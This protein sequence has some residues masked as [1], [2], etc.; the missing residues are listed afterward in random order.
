MA[1]EGPGK[2]KEKKNRAAKPYDRP[3]G[4]IRRVTDSVTGLFS[5]SWLSGWMASE[6]EEEAGEHPQADTSQIAS[7]SR[8][9]PQVNTLAPPGESFIFAQ[10]GASRRSFRP[11]YPEEGEI[12][13]N[14]HLPHGIN[15]GASTSAG[16]RMNLPAAASVAIPTVTSVHLSSDTPSPMLT[17]RRLPIVSSAP[18][19]MYSA[20]SKSHLEPR[21][22]PLLTS[23]TPTGDDASEFS[24]SSADTG[25]DASV[26]PRPDE[27]DYQREI[28]Q[29]DDESL[30][31]LR[32]SLAK[33]APVP[34]SQPTSA[35]PSLEETR[36]RPRDAETDQTSIR[37]EGSVSSRSLFSETGEISINQPQPSALA[38]KRPRFN[39]SAYGSS[40]MVD[41][42][43]LSNSS[44]KMSPF[45]PGKT[46][47]GGASA[48]RKGKLQSRAQT[49]RV[50][51]KPK[52]A[53]P[54]DD[55]GL[56]Q[57][58][59][60]I[61]E[62][63]EQMS[64]PIS[65][66]KRIPTPIPGQRGSF[67]DAGSSY[68]AVYHK[69]RPL[70]RQAGPPASK[71]STP[72][73]VT[74]QEN[75]S[76]NLLVNTSSGSSSSCIVPNNTHTTTGVVSSNANSRIET[77]LPTT[78]GNPVSSDSASREEKEELKN[79]SKTPKEDFSLSFSKAVAEAT[80][81]Y[82]PTV[83]VISSSA[84]SSSSLFSFGSPSNVSSSQTFDYTPKPPSAVSSDSKKQS[85]GKVKSKVVNS[86]RTSIRPED[87]EVEDPKLPAVSLA[88]T[89]L[90]KIDLTTP[91]EVSS[92]PGGFKFS[93]PEVVHSSKVPSETTTST[94][95]FVFSSPV[96][97]IRG[98]ANCFDSASTVSS[99][100]LLF[101]SCSPVSAPKLKEI[102]RKDKPSVAGELKEGSILDILK[103]KSKSP[104]KMP[105]EHL[106]S[107]SIFYSIDKTSSTSIGTSFM[108]AHEISSKF[109]LEQTVSTINSVPKKLGTTQV[110]QGFSSFMKK[111]DE[112]ECSVCMVRNKNGIEKCVACQTAR[113]SSKSL[114]SPKSDS[115]FTN[116]VE[117]ST[118]PV[119][120]SE[121][122]WGESFKKSTNEW[123]CE[124]C[125]VRNKNTSGKCVACET[126]KP[127]GRTSEPVM[128][129]DC[130]KV[131][132]SKEEKN[133]SGFGSMFAKAKGEWE[134]ATCLVRNKSDATKCISC[135]TAKP[136]GVVVSQAIT[137]NFKF[138]VNTGNDSSSTSSVY[139]FGLSD[140]K[141]DADRT[142]S[143]SGG[144]KFGVSA[145]SS[146]ES[147]S[148][149]SSSVGVFK[150]GVS[151]DKESALTVSSTE[152]ENE[153]SKEKKEYVSSSS[154]T[155]F[156][157]GVP[158]SGKTK[159][160]GKESSKALNFSFSANAAAK[161]TKTDSSIKS[162]FN[163][164]AESQGTPF[165]FGV[166][167]KTD[168]KGIL[169]AYKPTPE[170]N[171]GSA[172]DAA[173]S[174]DSSN[175]FS[176]FVNSENS[177]GKAAPLFN[178]TLS[179]THSDDPKIIPTFGG[180]K[181][182]ESAPVAPAPNNSFTF[183]NGTNK[184]P[185][186]NLFSFAS[187]TSKED[188]SSVP[189]FSFTSKREATDSEEP[190]KKS[191]FGSSTLSTHT[192]NVNAAS[193]FSFG[194]KENSLTTGSGFGPPTTS[195]PAFGAPAPASNATP[196]FQFG[197]PVPAATAPS[198]AFGG[199]SSTQTF[200][201]SASAFSSGT[202]ST[203]SFAF[204]QAANKK[205]AGFDFGQAAASTPNQGFTFGAASP[206]AVFQFGQKQTEPSGG[207]FQFGAGNTTVDVS[208]PTFGSGENP[209][210]PAP[211]SG[212]VVKKKNL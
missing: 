23:S 108:K 211:P 121:I 109:G 112:W 154:S 209:F 145:K 57:A 64:T 205:S 52:P 50:Q 195:T 149:E 189:S 185:S 45:Y 59:R 2:F 180:P 137:G 126:P 61:L 106:D 144:F 44:F 157:F 54:S 12:E 78:V 49:A 183:G 38:S 97:V 117:S 68:T 13:N 197:T 156:S 174:K 74:S 101:N 188:K 24:E 143:M 85:G 9:T 148:K 162:G 167:S 196:N 37:A 190:A 25:V 18:S 164:K 173:K 150:F 133:N 160:V 102:V 204:G 169:P 77:V 48:Y 91:A 131:S 146:E 30:Q 92:S 100:P 53:Q 8:V 207:L 58:A 47:F 20:R 31:T 86:T 21:P 139:K 103:P 138:G 17:G 136:G 212:R 65:D 75:L 69:Y 89:S 82:K 198:P 43:V 208:A 147:K 199:A 51:V 116:A 192:N 11:I 62:C 129:Q 4:I 66:A 79:S 140:A 153:K 122:G 113:P 171:C 104:E 6:E 60:R 194:S 111:N 83:P 72:V 35:L 46:M 125:M 63:L 90:P 166:G 168:D 10:P 56:S 128:S 193:L 120:T 95:V 151:G 179:S 119:S 42:S 55:G 14:S 105:N 132:E 26:I 73:K 123:E 184:A 1:S 98:N 141:S 32:E 84:I 176:S 130:C 142:S 94:P 175:L 163:F 80:A 22:L 206:N 165:T 88:L 187:S 99:A 96:T 210:T 186:A 70:V 3:K 27:R 159:E 124:T 19:Q 87:E 172:T 93:S 110:L 134:C 201:G 15:V 191:T 33:S 177:E 152:V 7:Q 5:S 200:S 81:K 28:L 161:E 114:F 181:V 170:L 16:V 39:V 155:G 34:P 203:P 71:H 40:F 107:S 67:L 115:I 41:R 36:K 202:N 182:S 178:N 29:L 76:A 158:P 127:D 135:E 118:L